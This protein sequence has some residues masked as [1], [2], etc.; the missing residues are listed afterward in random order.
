MKYKL[1]VYSIWECGKRVDGEGKPHQ[2]DCI[3]PLPSEMRPGDRT[4][5]LCDGMGGHDRG[6][7]ASSTVCDVMG[8]SIL[9]DGHDAEGIFTDDDLKKAVDDALTALDALDN[10]ASRKMGTTMTLLKLHNRGATIAHIGDS[11]VYHIRPGKDGNDTRILFVTTDHSL[12]NELVKAGEMTPEEARCSRQR[13]I[14]TRAMQPN[15]GHRPKADVYHTADIR[16]GDYF[17]MCSDG[18][19]EQPDMDSGESLRNIFSEMG[20]SAEKK[21]RM[22]ISV[23]EGNHDNH[24]ALII[25]IDKIVNEGNTSDVLGRLKKLFGK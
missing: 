5:I 12:V 2:E 25:R 13:N 7:V 3:Y 9:H 21:V 11:R 14:I 17:Y 24:T 8:H 20:G 15:L 4:F 23:T 1:S 19:L 22:L 18:M 6:E 10:G 16:E